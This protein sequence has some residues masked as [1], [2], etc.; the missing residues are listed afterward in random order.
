MSFRNAVFLLLPT[1][2]LAGALRYSSVEKNNTTT[3]S[4]APC[5]LNFP[6]TI[7][8]LIATPLDCA[9]L[10]VPLD[11]SNP[12]SGRKIQLQLIRVPSTQQPAKGSIIFNVGGPG[13]SGV[14][15]IATNGKVYSDVFGGEYNI[16]GFDPR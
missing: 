10:R 9:N 16:V 2:A 12:K 14:K 6:E 7:T 13:G 3:L 11:Y 8:E 1:T 4:W 15:E 5:N